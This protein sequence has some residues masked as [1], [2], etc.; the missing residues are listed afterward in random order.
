MFVGLNRDSYIGVGHNSNFQNRVTRCS[1]AV[2]LNLLGSH[3][4]RI[5]R[6]VFTTPAKNLYRRKSGCYFRNLVGTRGSVGNT[7]ALHY[8]VDDACCLVTYL[9]TQSLCAVQSPAGPG[10]E[11]ENVFSETKAP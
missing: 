9:E 10:L 8:T 6:L 4:P 7:S 2:V 1:K 11:L 5:I 3:T